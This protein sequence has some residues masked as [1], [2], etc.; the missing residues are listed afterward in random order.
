MEALRVDI[1]VSEFRK[2]ADKKN[3]K[4]KGRDKV[5]RDILSEVPSFLCERIGVEVD[6]KTS[7][8]MTA[9]D[10]LQKQNVLYISRGQLKKHTSTNINF[11]INIHYISQQ[12]RMLLILWRNESLTA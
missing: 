10:M 1:V 9:D 11:T 7:A 4:G 6:V 2:T 12:V 5:Q 3:S 8:D